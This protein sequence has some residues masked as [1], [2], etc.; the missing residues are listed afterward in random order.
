MKRIIQYSLRRLY[1]ILSGDD[2]LGRACKDI[3]ESGCHE[4]PFNFSL[5]IANGAA[6][7]LAEQIAGPNII[8]VWLLQLLGSPVWILG[9]L[10]PVKQAG[11]LLPQMIAAG[12]IRRL[13]IRKWVW[14]TASMGQGL[15]L[16][17]MIPAA[18]YLGPVS[19][20]VS[21][22]LLFTLFSIASGTASVAF[23][24]VLGKTIVKGHRG[25]LLASRA[26]VGG[27]LTMSAGTWLSRVKS[28]SQ[29]ELSTVFTLIIIGAFLWI[30]AA[31]FFAATREQ[32][33]ETQGGRN[34]WHE[35]RAGIETFK[36]YSGFR[37]FLTTRTLLLSVE[38]ATPFYFIHARD[39]LH[40]ENSLV[41]YLVITIGL[42]QVLSSPFWG[43]LADETSKS[44][45]RHSALLSVAAAL[46]AVTLTILP[47]ASWHLAGYLLVFLLLGLAEAGVRLGRK[48][49][50]VDA[51]PAA[52]RASGAAFTNSC[53]GVLALFSG[54]AGFIAHCYGTTAVIICFAIGALISTVTCHFMPE[55]DRMLDN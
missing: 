30:L 10:M 8:L 23:Q 21:I 53:V 11:S 54:I 29:D 38:L 22:L 31:F 6:S 13:S 5:N 18:L 35:A 14:V 16:M 51:L 3:P 32:P 4:M 47:A 9:F 37:W 19:A 55:A 15:C 52:E 20:G 2:G 12:Q 28:N 40:L 50:L 24:D 1:T 44:V 36:R 43:R 27:I 17:L 34:A 48:T 7:K 39:Q 26:L 33:G 42:A 45:M 41:G 46:L 49:Y 25:K